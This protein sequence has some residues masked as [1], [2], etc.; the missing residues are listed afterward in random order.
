MHKFLSILF[1]TCFLLTSCTQFLTKSNTETSSAALYHSYSS[2]SDANKKS[3]YKQI[4]RNIEFEYVDIEPDS[5][6]KVILM[7]NSGLNEGTLEDKLFI[8]LKNGDELALELASSNSN[9]YV[10]SYSYNS[11]VP[12][13][14]TKTINDPGG[15]DLQVQADGTHKQVIRPASS[16]TVQVTENQNRNHAG[17]KTQLFNKGRLFLNADHIQQ[18]KT[19]GIAKFT[20]YLEDAILDIFPNTSHNNQLKKNL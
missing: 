17:S 18:I 9:E 12:V 5:M 1:C 10:E 19:H 7:F 3:R 2:K 4:N 13:T 6:A 20:V 16:K 8:H 15:I 14:Q 11:S